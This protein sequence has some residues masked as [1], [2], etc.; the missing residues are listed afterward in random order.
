MQNIVLNALHE[1]FNPLHLWHIYYY[2]HPLLEI[3]INQCLQ[4]LNELIKFI[5]LVN[6]RTGI[7]TV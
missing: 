1:L 5:K 4:K 2:H 6:R 3:N 7:Q